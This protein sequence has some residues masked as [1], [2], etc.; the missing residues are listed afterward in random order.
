MVRMGVIGTHAA[1]AGA[2]FEVRTFI[3]G[4]PAA[5]DPVTGRVHVNALGEEVWVGGSSTT[6]ISGTVLL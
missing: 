3:P 2:D 1:D 6:C 5:E 4:D